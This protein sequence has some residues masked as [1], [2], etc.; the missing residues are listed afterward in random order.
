MGSFSRADVQATA[1]GLER[2]LLSLRNEKGVWEGYLSSSPLATAV[3][4]FALFCT[5]A[6]TYEEPIRRADAWIVQSQNADGGW[7]D[8][9]GAD[10]SNLSTTLL[11]RAALSVDPQAHADSIRRAEGWIVQRIGG[12]EPARIVDAVYA[13]Y[14]NDRT[15]AVPIL[16]M[17]ALAGTLGE[18]RAAWKAIVPLPFEL[19]MFPRSLFRWLNLSVVSYALPA[20]IAIGQ[21]KFVHDPPANPLSRMMRQLSIGPT[22]NLL[23]KIQPVN[24]GYLE[25]APLTGFVVMSLASMEQKSHP[26][27]QR[28]IEFLLQSMR[29]DGS[30]PID[31]NLASWVTSLV[32]KALYEKQD[33]AVF[34]NEEKDR[35]VRWYLDQQMK[36]VHP[37]TGAPPGGWGWTDRPGSVPDADDTAGAL[38]ALYHLDRENDHVQAAARRG[39]E[40]LMGLQNADGGIPT[41]C[42][43][44][45]KLEFDRSSPDITAHAVQAFSLWKGCFSGPFEK[46]IARSMRR[47]VTYLQKIQR[48]DGS[49][50]PLWFGSPWAKDQGNPVYGTARVISGIAENLPNQP[51]CEAMACRAISF[52]LAAHNEDG[53]WGG[54]QG[55]CSSIEETAMAVGALLDVYP[56]L[57]GGTGTDRIEQAIRSGAGFLLK[58]F[59]SPQPVKTSAIGLY[60]AKLWY[61]ERLY[62]TVFTLFSLHAYLQRD[63]IH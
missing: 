9:D 26:V 59:N 48:E 34:P 18:G 25:A 15:F 3:A 8:T 51:G 33:G 47:A 23:S 22:R 19:A 52:L 24:G 62:P 17:C 27:V 54:Q 42:R 56:C 35:V 20:L 16:T 60:F 44:W 53:G 32:V 12:L 30:W 58:N 6:E 38:V 13:S 5:D 46:R 49:F 43:G 31:T 29:P 2:T 45:G 39:I 21:V 36:C 10:P 57:S 7:G 61:S 11:C 63:R 4:S 28:G 41:F 50:Y 37:F 1:E 40:W 55:L 14:G